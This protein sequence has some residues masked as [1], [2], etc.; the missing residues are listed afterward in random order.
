[1]TAHIR[2]ATLAS[3]TGLFIALPGAALAQTSDEQKRPPEIQIVVR[4]GDPRCE[5]Q[6]LRVPADAN[7]DL[8]IQ[9]QSG[10]AVVVHAPDLFGGARVRAATDA[11]KDGD[12]YAVA[13]RANAQM[14]VQ[15]PPQGEYRYACSDQGAAAGQMT[16]KLVT[17]NSMQ[18]GIVTKGP[19]ME[20]PPE[21]PPGPTERK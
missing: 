15:T 18:P 16:G 12:G 6:E 19:G 10:R 8:R 9:N 14:I 1:M 21:R 3:A 5:P 2:L 17:V 11:T 13:S 4:D 7:I 20:H